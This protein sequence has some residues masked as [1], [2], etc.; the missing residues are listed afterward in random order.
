MFLTRKSA[1]KP[2]PGFQKNSNAWKKTKPQ[3]GDEGAIS[4]TVLLLILIAFINGLDIVSGNGLVEIT[5]AEAIK[6]N[7]VDLLLFPFR[8]VANWLTMA[9]FL[10]FYW[11]FGSRLEASMKTKLYGA[12]LLCGYICVL[13]GTLFYPL[14]AYYVFF[15]VFLAAAWR[16]PDMEIYLF[17]IIP[18][19]LKWAAFF[20]L[21]LLAYPLLS[22]AYSAMDLNPLIGFVLGFA[23]FLIFHSKDMYLRLGGRK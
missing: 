5:L 19:K 17:F 15:S 8:I 10:Y 23:N 1:P 7:W 2:Q 6:G 16:E 3:S 20:S 4:I 11:L 9:L 18:I 14:N 13:L 22:S 12:Y 21:C